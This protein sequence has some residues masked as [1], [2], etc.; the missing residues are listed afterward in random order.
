MKKILPCIITCQ[1]LSTILFAQSVGINNNAPHASAILDVR[2][3][4][5]GFLMPRMTTAQRNAIASPAAGLKVYDTDTNTFWFYNGTV[6][7]PIAAGNIGW[8]LAGNNGTNPAT[9]FIGTTDEQ[10]LRF[11]VNNLWAGEMHPTSGNIFLGVGAGQTNT[12][13]QA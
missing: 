5:K 12:A 1:L 8:N 7:L 6:W 9:H 11:R 3:S 13:G 2:S 10:P 4:T